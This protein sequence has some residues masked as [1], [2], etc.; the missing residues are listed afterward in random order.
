MKRRMLISPAILFLLILI[1]PVPTL[2]HDNEHKAKDDHRSPGQYEEGSGMKTHSKKHGDYQEH[3]EYEKHENPSGLTEEGSNMK[4][5]EKNHA[6]Y[7]EHGEYEKH[8]K[9]SEHAEEGSGMR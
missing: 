5:K 9:P 6:D 1:V 2:A 4:M 8:G 3:G 7:Q